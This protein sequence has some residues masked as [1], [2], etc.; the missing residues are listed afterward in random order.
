MKPTK[1]VLK[2]SRRLTYI[3]ALVSLIACVLVMCLPFTW[4]YKAALLLMIILA[5]AYA[6]ARDALLILPCSCHLLILNKDN[7]IVVTQKNGKK[8]VVKILPTS[9]VM[10]QLT[11]INMRA[12]GQLWSRNMI[13]LADNADVEEARLWQVWLKWGLKD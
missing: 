12:K 8:F 5:A 1:L 10:P 2:P 4:L 11:V 3:L 9:L 7:E 13:L 6:T